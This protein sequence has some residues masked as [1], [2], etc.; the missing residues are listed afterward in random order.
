M[1]VDRRTEL[2]NL[3]D[4]IRD[5]VVDHPTEVIFASFEHELISNRRPID[6]INGNWMIEIMNCR[7][8]AFRVA[9]MIYMVSIV[10]G[11]MGTICAVFTLDIGHLMTNHVDIKLAEGAYIVV[12]PMS[13][14]EGIP[15][16]QQS[17][18][19]HRSN[20]VRSNWVSMCV[21][22]RII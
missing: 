21:I 13:C 18:H 17:L 9:Y 11:V 3:N 15:L 12:L 8:D 16:A 19:K 1:D 5:Y 7:A 22:N 20:N 10:F 14:C 2:R 4:R 6:E